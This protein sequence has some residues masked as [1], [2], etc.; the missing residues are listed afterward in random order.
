MTRVRIQE[1]ETAG[2]TGQVWIR[3]T[4]AANG[5]AYG[6]R[7][8]WTYV[9]L[10]D[11]YTVNGTTWQPVTGLSFAPAVS[12]RYAIEGF[13]G[14][15]CSNIAYGPI[16]GIRWPTAGITDAWAIVD[17]S[18]SATGYRSYV[19]GQLTADAGPSITGLPDTTNSYPT[20]LQA[21]LITTTG[22]TGAFQ[23]IFSADQAGDV[24]MQAG[25]Y[26]RYREF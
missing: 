20:R 16:V 23:I 12:S 25:S 26:I 15:R 1:F 8:D 5:G 18:L 6:V 19:H 3:D 13:I 22:V 17:G 24:T 2:S 4:L 21:T 11:G 9:A 10:E 14:V 7:D